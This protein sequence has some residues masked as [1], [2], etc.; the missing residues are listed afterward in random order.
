MR[1]SNRVSQTLVVM[2]PKGTAM[3]ENKSVAI[4]NNGRSAPAQLE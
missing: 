1:L 3:L 4:N 2:I